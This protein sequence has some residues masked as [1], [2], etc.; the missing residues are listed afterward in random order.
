MK[1]FLL[2]SLALIVALVAQVQAEV[3]YSKELEKKAMNGDAN[4][5]NDLAICYAEGKG[6]A[7]DA[8]KA[9]DLW[10]Q[11]ASKGNQTAM[12]YLGDA[13]YYGY[14]GMTKSYEKALEYWLKAT[15]KSYAWE[16]LATHYC[17]GY[18]VTQD[19][20][21]VV[22]WAG[23]AANAGK[24]YSQYLLGFCYYYGKGIDKDTEEGA[25]WIL[26][27]A[28][29]KDQPAWDWLNK[30][31][32]EDDYILVQLGLMYV[33][34]DGVDLD[35]A[36][37]KDYWEKA[38]AKG[39]DTAMYHI[40]IMYRMGEGM[41]KDRSKAME[42]FE[43]AAQ[44][45]HTGSMNAIASMYYDNKDYNKAREWY[46]KAVDAGS[47]TAMHNMGAVYADMG[48]DATA[49]SWYKKAADCGSANDMF[50]LGR[51]YYYGTGVSKSVSQALDWFAKG[52]IHFEE[53]DISDNCI[54]WILGICRNDNKDGQLSR[55]LSSMTELFNKYS[56][57]EDENCTDTGIEPMKLYYGL[58]VCYIYGI[59]TQKNLAKA[60]EC[61]LNC[62]DGSV[63]Y[64]CWAADI[65]EH[66]DLG[67]KDYKKALSLNEIYY[68][69]PYPL[70]RAAT[71]YIEGKGVA[72]N[73][74]KAIKLLNEAIDAIHWIAGEEDSAAEAK[75]LL[76]DLYLKGNGVTQN[77]N[78]AF[79]LFK[80]AAE[81]KIDPN[82]DAMLS[83]AMCYRYGKGTTKNL[84]KANEWEQK[85]EEAG[86]DEART[87]NRERRMLRR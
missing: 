80:Q 61:L 79:E 42:W 78:K 82:P 81:D 36:K 24:H 47:L 84:S 28:K 40:G 38:A 71:F 30:H 53:D 32:E 3:T 58:A 56:S 37:A 41:N 13:Y 12:L 52:A 4:A 45:G 87:R 85:A 16:K 46:Q 77:S 73:Y 8:S 50:L 17:F 2:I 39:S 75:Y 70:T 27:A 48:D 14:H 15:D 9:I 74:A 66:G 22:K 35:Y 33:T 63:R 64:R 19:Y 23:K 76:G 10:Q 43:K 6:I 67:S 60:R 7:K 20:A 25:D 29:Q 21:E 65:Y 69:G 68:G 72:K 57:V 1:K 44:K 51:K 18:G 83:L 31:A 62:E 86:S 34:G 55:Q 54:D 5:M 11:A 59:G 26:K 49:I